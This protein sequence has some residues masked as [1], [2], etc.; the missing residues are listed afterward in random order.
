MPSKW[1]IYNSQAEASVLERWE[2]EKVTDLLGVLV[3][4][5]ETFEL[6]FHLAV[7]KTR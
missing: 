2:A 6:C 5:V 1:D 3:A 4:T 7:R